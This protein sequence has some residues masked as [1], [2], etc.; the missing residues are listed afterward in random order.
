MNPFNESRAPA[1]KQ[2]PDEFLPHEG[3]EQAFDLLTL[4]KRSIRGRIPITI[5]AA[6]VLGILFAIV[7]YTRTGLE[8]QSSATF[9]VI[10]IIGVTGEVLTPEM[11]NN[12]LVTRKKLEFEADEVLLLAASD[13]RLQDVGWPSSER[14]ASWL[15]SAISTDSGRRTSYFTATCTTSDPKTARI[16]LQAVTDA[17]LR[18]EEEKSGVAQRE[19]ELTNLIRK[20]DSDI[21]L[22]ESAIAAATAEY[23]TPDLQPQ[24]TLLD[25]NRN[26]IQQEIEAL[27]LD[28]QL[29]Q[30]ENE[31]LANE[32]ENDSDELS[33]EALA[34]SDTVLQNLL[35][36]KSQLAVRIDYLI[37][38]RGTRNPEVKILQGQ[39]DELEAQIESRAKI[40]RELIKNGSGEIQIGE[41]T[42]RALRARL[43]AQIQNQATIDQELRELRAAQRD[44][45]EDVESRDR[46]KN[47]KRRLNEELDELRINQQRMQEGQVEVLSPPSAPKQAGDKRP[48]LAGLGFMA[49]AFMGVACIIALGAMKRSFR[50]VDELETVRSLP[51]LLGT[52]PELEKHDPENER[53][54][55]VSVH[56]LRNTMQAIQGFGDNNSVVI[57]CTSAEPGD[58]KTTLIQSLGASY[59]LTGLRTILV[60]LDLIGGGMS[61]R[62]GLSG[63]RGIA[64]L[65]T[66]LEPTKCIKHTS[67]DKLYAMPIGDTSKCKPEQLA[68]RPIQQV[69]DWLRERFD[70]ILVDTG[71][72]LG[73]LEAGIVTAAADQVLLVVARGQSDNVVQAAV[74]RLE[75][76]GVL[77]TGLVFNRADPEDLRRSLSAASVGAPSMHQIPRKTGERS[78]DMDRSIVG[79]IPASNEE[80]IGTLNQAED[81][82][83]T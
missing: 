23:G 20:L 10:D 32:N 74:S 61:A 69:I 1:S 41:L 4:A 29:R 75:R 18:Y 15:R 12:D 11:R 80:R 79:S 45:A 26:R 36:D 64:D 70:V 47:T 52:L 8:Y 3:E 9:D 65:L 68:S 38:E 39:L 53:I 77:S 58:G 49:G 30:D 76:L 43:D 13:A 21:D 35:L 57:A 63:R 42:E 81:E 24:I 73:S 34:P 7:G 6:A 66:G 17:F 56:N 51:P 46:F 5:A 25:A 82:T 16:A 78:L 44:I 2:T 83:G 33:A 50:Y 14:G 54:A 55:A 72:V 67:T 62:L 48:V 31:N 27:R 60:D 37:E 59:A 28:L 19:Q 22:V 40:V 71:P